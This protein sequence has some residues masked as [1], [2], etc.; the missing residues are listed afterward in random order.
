LKF[1]ASIGI[2]FTYLAASL[3]TLVYNQLES[4]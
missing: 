4:V 3:T 2:E 1:V